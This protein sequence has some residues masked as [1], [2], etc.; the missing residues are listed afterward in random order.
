MAAIV[1]SL[2]ALGLGFRHRVSMSVR[3]S[4]QGPIRPD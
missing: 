2:I 1:A 3:A 4:A